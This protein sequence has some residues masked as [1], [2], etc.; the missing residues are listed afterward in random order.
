MS[1]RFLWK[2]E[3]VYKK[4]N[5]N[6]SMSLDKYLNFLTGERVLERRPEATGSGYGYIVA[7]GFKDSAKKLIESSLPNSKVKEV[8][9]KILKKYHNL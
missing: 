7:Q 1:G 5:I 2:S 4:A 8:I 3:S 9:K 6:G